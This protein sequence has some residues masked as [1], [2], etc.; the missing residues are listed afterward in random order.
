MEGGR[1]NEQADRGKRQ[2]GD[3]YVDARLLYAAF[4]SVRLPWLIRD[5]PISWGV[6]AGRSF[7]LQRN[8]A[9]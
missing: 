3:V 5:Q 8:E 2:Q 6:R 9:L 1:R 7:L 4:F